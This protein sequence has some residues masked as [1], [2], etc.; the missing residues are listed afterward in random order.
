M[1]DVV[2]KEPTP[3]DEFLLCYTSGTTGVP[4]GAKI[5]HRYMINSFNA[6]FMNRLS[7]D[8][9]TYLSYLP[10][11]HIFEQLLFSLVCCSG[12]KCG[13]YSGDNLKIIEDCGILKPTHFWSVPRLYNKIHDML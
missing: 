12:M 2:R 1:K 13:C 11:A 8:V 10:A 6:M 9:S 3:E 7:D 4:K 5:S